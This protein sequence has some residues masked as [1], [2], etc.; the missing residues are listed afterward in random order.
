MMRVAVFPSRL[1]AFETGFRSL[2]PPVLPF[3]KY[4]RANHTSVAQNFQAG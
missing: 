2:S 3:S 4:Q 1:S